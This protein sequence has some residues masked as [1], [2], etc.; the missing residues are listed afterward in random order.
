MYTVVLQLTSCYKHHYS[1]SGVI[2]CVHVDLM[3]WDA[4]VGKPLE[5]WQPFFFLPQ[6]QMLFNSWLCSNQ[7]IEMKC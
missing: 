2:C 5:R 7:N 4:I 3:L 6:N 1:P